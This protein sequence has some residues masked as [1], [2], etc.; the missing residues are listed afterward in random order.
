[1]QQGRFFPNSHEL[2]WTC[3]RDKGVHTTLKAWRPSSSVC[4]YPAPPWPTAA[5]CS[6]QTGRALCPVHPAALLSSDNREG[7]S[8]AAHSPPDPLSAHRTQRDTL[9]MVPGVAMVTE[10]CQCLPAC[11]LEHLCET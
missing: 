7:V 9:S 2:R 5:P 10:L 11:V 3:A 4:P 6:T 8:L 1:M